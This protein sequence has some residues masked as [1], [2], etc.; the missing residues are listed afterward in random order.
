MMSLTEDQVIRY[1]R[2]ILLAQVGGSGQEKLLATGAQL[3]GQGAAQATAAAYLAAGGIAVRAMGQTPD[4]REAQVQ[5]DET[6]FLL[7]EHDAGRPLANALDSALSDL[8]P[9]ARTRR[10]TGSLGEMPA[11]FSGPAPWVALG[12]RERRGEVVY[13]S[14]AGCADCFAASLRGLTRVPPGP[15]SVLL[16]TVAALVFQRLCLDGSDELGAVSI[17]SGGEIQ[18]ISPSRCLQCG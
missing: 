13:R 14:E 15:H 2:Q 3:V 17:E 11:D 10:T 8:N 4:S 7:G 1:S 18:N 16:G 12:W 6:G 9:D 5:P